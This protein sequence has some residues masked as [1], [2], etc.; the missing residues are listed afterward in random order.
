MDKE[1][2]EVSGIEFI[3]YFDL[4]SGF[5]LMLML[6]GV[7]GI[8]YFDSEVFKDVCLSTG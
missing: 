1:L 2:K 3:G 6:W 5:K 8:F 7:F 4:F